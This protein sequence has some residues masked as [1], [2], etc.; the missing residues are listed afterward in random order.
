MN[1]L[2]AEDDAPSRLM[3]QSLLTR[4]G[5]TIIPASDGNEAWK[6]LCASATGHP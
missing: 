5:Y 1:V 4:W 2:I 6:I 3:L